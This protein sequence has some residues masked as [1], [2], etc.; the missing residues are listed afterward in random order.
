MRGFQE[1]EALAKTRLSPVISVDGPKGPPRVAKEGAAALARRLKIPMIPIG[2]AADRYH[3]LG[4]WDQMILPWPGT[5]AVIVVG[6]PVFPGNHRRDDAKA[7]EAL[8]EALNEATEIA[9][10][11]FDQLWRQGA[12]TSPLGESGLTSA[13]R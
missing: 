11:D 5:R 10:T 2:F 3:R 9:K 1:L 7:T 4:T 13:G 8:G 6:S 12:G